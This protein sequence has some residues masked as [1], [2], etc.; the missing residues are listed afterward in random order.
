M[1]QYLL[2]ILFFLYFNSSFGQITSTKYVLPMSNGMEISAS[3]GDIRP[4]HFHTGIDF[5]TNGKTGLPIKSIDKG[6]VG[7]IKIMPLSYGQVIYINHPNGITSVYAHCSKFNDHI[8]KEITKYQKQKKLNEIDWMPS[9]TIWIE[10]GEMIAYSGNT[11]NSTGPHLHFELRQTTTDKALNPFK[12]GFSYTD[13]KAPIPYSVYFYNVDDKGY[14]I[15]STPKKSPLSIVNNSYV[16]SGSKVNLD[17]TFFSQSPYFIIGIQ[18]KDPIGSSG[19]LAGLYEQKLFVNDKLYFHCI[20]DTIAFE[21]NGYMNDYC[22]YNTYEFKDT[23]VHK[24]FYKSVNPLELYKTPYQNPIQFK[25]QKIKITIELT[26]VNSNKRTIAFEINGSL[27]KKPYKTVF[28]DQDY[29]MPNKPYLFENEN[30]KFQIGDSTLIEPLPRKSQQF[31]DKNVLFKGKEK[32]INES[33][34]IKLKTL[35]DISIEK[36]YIQCTKASGEK[37]PCNTKFSDGWLQTKSKNYGTYGVVKDLTKPTIQPSTFTKTDSTIVLKSHNW[38]IGDLQSGIKSYDL[39]IDEKWTPVYY[40]KKNKWIEVDKSNLSVGKHVFKV[41]VLDYCA[42]SLT[43][44]KTL[45]VT[46]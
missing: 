46:K 18:A 32:P 8:Q 4:D 10:R 7:R 11:G 17:S 23:K 39:Y 9:D 28:D 1:N 15:N 36:Q 2:S 25:G 16:V 31:V 29:L 34:E 19:T 33:F 26:D 42:N 21:H 24:L 3:F 12:H 6:Y 44:K 22:D 30:A 41:V 45:T 43:W 37:I 20:T 27:K 13:T 38:L 14:H 40:D 5:K 35:S